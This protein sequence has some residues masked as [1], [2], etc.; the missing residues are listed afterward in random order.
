MNLPSESAIGILSPGIRRIKHLAAFLGEEVVAVHPL[1]CTT[2][3][4]NGVAGWGR[5]PAARKAQAYAKARGI[6]RYLCLE[7]GFLR[8]LH[9]GANSRT[10]SLVVDDLGIYYDASGPS[11]LEE[12]VV[13][14]LGQAERERAQRLIVH[15]H[16]HHTM[17]ARSLCVV[18]LV[19]ADAYSGR[20]WGLTAA[21]NMLASMLVG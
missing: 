6:E 13:M 18:G 11:R 8:S 10:C 15:W 5:R 19:A 12:L 20:S 4:L 3:P 17:L 21:V 16:G 7:D 2:R 1:R 14:P 9:P